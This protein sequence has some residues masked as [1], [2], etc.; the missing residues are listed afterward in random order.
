MACVYS[1]RSS[2]FWMM[3]VSLTGLAIT[4]CATSVSTTTDKPRLAQQ[5][6]LSTLWMDRAGEY[7]A[8][9]HQAFNMAKL[10]VD[11]RLSYHRTL[12]KPLAVIVDID[13]TVLSNVPYFSQL[14]D[15]GE[16]FPRGWKVWMQMS[17][18]QA[19][20]GA[21]EFLKYARFRGVE[22]FY[23]SN[24]SINEGLTAT[25]NNL[26][27]MDFPFADQRHLL[28]KS[29]SGNKQPR[30]D[31]VEQTHEVILL[32]GDNLNDFSLIF[33]DKPVV[34]RNNAVDM[35]SSEFGKRFI[36]LPNPIYGDWEGA[37][38]DYQWGTSS[39]QKLK[40]RQQLYNQ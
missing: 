13:E 23:I 15:K 38:Y 27:K 5:S 25:I 3:L 33:S 34:Q 30:R 40:V 37:L 2:L 32:I 39:A 20:P 36:I 16:V 35:M 7:R 24:R 19:I 10:Q 17:T 22:V 28:L 6:V 29:K 9:C 21:L 12:E 31:R 14:I 18:A 26:V 1:M 4:G 11:R 8:L